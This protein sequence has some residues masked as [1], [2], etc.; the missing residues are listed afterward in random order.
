MADQQWD[1]MMQM[2]TSELS[3]LI[4]SIPSSLLEHVFKDQYFIKDYKLPGKTVVCVQT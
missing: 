4:V 3:Y 1:T 2:F